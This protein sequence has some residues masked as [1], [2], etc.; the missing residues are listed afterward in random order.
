V[1][2]GGPLLAACAAVEEGVAAATWTLPAPAKE[3]GSDGTTFLTSFT[4]Q[5]SHNDL[6]QSAEIPSDLSLS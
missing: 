2:G 5:E 3:T 6:F 4:Y 1:V